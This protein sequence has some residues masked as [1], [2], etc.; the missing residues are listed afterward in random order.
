MSKK[1]NELRQKRNVLITQGRD[2]LN[3]VEQEK[4]NLTV[5]EQTQYDKLFADQD[6]LRKAV[7]T[8]E[9]QVEAER[10]LATAQL[11]AEPGAG[12]K[13]GPDCHRALAELRLVGRRV[14]KAHPLA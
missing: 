2:L 8:E 13:P 3:K 9:R 5:E 14:A 4:R 10:S 12:D 1:L 11:A 6:D 7:E